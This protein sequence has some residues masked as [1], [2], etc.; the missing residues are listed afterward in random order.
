[1][2]GCTSPT[3]KNYDPSATEDDGSCVWLSNIEGTCYEFI[4]VPEDQVVDHSFTLSMALNPDTLQPVGWVFFHDYF[5]D[6][7]VHTR[8]KLLNLKNN[9]PFFQSAGPKG[10]YHFNTDPKPFFVDI[11]FAGTPALNEPPS[12]RYQKSYKPY[13]SMVLN[14]VNWITEVR[15]TAN[16]PIDDNQRALY[17]ETI[18]SVTIWNQYQTTG[19]INLT[20][21]LATLQADMNN[22]N[23]E[24]TWQFNEFRDVLDNLTDQF[25][26][27]IFSDYRM[28]S[29][30]LNTN[31]PW[32][33]QRLIEGKY[34]IVRFE[35]DNNNNKQITL[36][37]M[38]TDISKSYR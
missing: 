6:A 14:S 38:D 9:I 12:A 22:R 18:T 24:E 23:A 30:K 19:K 29:T 31:L 26:L 35:F 34:F 11:L 21:G 15:N 33:Q 17:L 2:Q 32:W 5:P 28:D 3:A 1:M 7:Y 4:E 16:D 20:G 25:I 27:D 10:I 13:P 36:H 8:D 37:D